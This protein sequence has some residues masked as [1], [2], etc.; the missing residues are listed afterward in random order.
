VVHA[1]VVPEIK[2]EPNC[3][4]ALAALEELTRGPSLDA[5]PFHAP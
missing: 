1:E 5:P 2:Q 3:E 4:K